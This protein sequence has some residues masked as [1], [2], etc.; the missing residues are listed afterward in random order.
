MALWKAS[1]CI[2]NL[3]DGEFWNPLTQIHGSMAIYF[4]ESD[5][6]KSIESLKVWYQ[7]LL[8]LKGL[9]LEWPKDSGKLSPLMKSDTQWSGNQKVPLLR[10]TVM[11]E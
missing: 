4:C 9:N 5:K 6:D 8:S 3:A 7:A 2:L 1:L 11:P 10:N